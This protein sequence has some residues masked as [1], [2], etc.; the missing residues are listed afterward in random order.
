MNADQRRCTVVE[1]GPMGLIEREHCPHCEGAVPHDAISYEP[2]RR[3]GDAYPSY[4]PTMALEQ[5][6]WKGKPPRLWVRP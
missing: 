4:L 1:A 3:G 6:F 5:T 2:A